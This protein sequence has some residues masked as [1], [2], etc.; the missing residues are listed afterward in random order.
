LLPQTV[1]V[2][3][4]RYTATGFEE[5]R[6]PVI[7]EYHVSFLLNG[8][9]YLTVACSG[10]DLELLAAGHLI[11]E[12]IIISQNEID[13]IEVDENGM[14]VNVITAKGAEIIGRLIKVRTLV[15]GCA[16][17]GDARSCMEP[18]F[19]D[20]PEIK[21]EVI[22]ASIKEFL[23]SSEGNRIT[24]GVHSGALYD[25]EGTRMA[26]FD[27]IGRHNAVDKLLGLALSRG[28]AVDRTML[29]TT[30]RVSSEIV[31]KAA[32]A[33]IPAIVKKYNIILITGVKRDA[34]YVHHGVEHISLMDHP[35]RQ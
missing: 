19:H 31:S 33:G 4:H 17:A 1:T 3:C 35:S 20:L 24:H 6:V 23:R 25:T 8:R 18:V 16:G 27:E 32:V 26:F 29:L 34:F 13:R 7:A 12:G 30:G 22:L 14:T 9:P 15:S 11:S 10:S 28:I 5:I 2:T 21:A